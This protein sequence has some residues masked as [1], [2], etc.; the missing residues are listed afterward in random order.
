MIQIIKKEDRHF[1]N[2]GW[3]KTYWLFSF[4]NYFDPNNIQFGAL[5]VFNDDVVAPGT[6]FP[7]HPHQ[8]MEIVTIVLQG[9]MT[10]E[11]SMGNKAVIQ[12]NDV[13]RMSAGTGLTHSEFNLADNP[14]HFYQI[15][16]F[17]D[18]SGLR[19]TYDQRTYAPVLWMN[20]LFPVA[21]GRGIPDTVTLHT[22]ATIYRAD[23]DQDQELSF[24]ATRGRRVFVYL[25]KGQLSI[26]GRQVDEGG[27][28]RIDTEEPLNFEAYKDAE[29]ILIDVPSCKGWGYSEETLRG[30]RR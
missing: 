1:S 26:N 3:L 2:F 19:P 6:G 28:A 23:L 18:K 17:P 20:T 12:A 16:I 9:E 8:E 24:E 27:Q 30:M 25:T 11:D 5:R 14:V 10:H 13:Q 15:W 4:A 21:S 7:T 29:F 22:D